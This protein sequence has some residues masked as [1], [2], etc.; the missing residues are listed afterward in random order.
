MINV[1]F[2]FDPLHTYSIP[3]NPTA[4]LAQA[5]IGAIIGLVVGAIGFVAA[6]VG[7][8]AACAALATASVPVIVTV[9]V[10]AAIVGL[11]IAVAGLISA[12]Q[13]T[14]QPAVFIPT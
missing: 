14:T 3:L 8:V 6:V 2:G 12:A 9:G 1:N 13:A 7:L 4:R 10:V 5:S 11:G